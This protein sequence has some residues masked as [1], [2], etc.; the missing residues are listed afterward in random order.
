MEL[1]LTKKDRFIVNAAAKEDVRPV[2]HSIHV[3]KGKIEC[4]NGF[5]LV[6]RAIDYDGDDILLDI[7]DIAR[8]KDAKGLDG[9]IYTKDGDNI[10]AIGQ[11]IN[12]I[13]PVEGKFPDTKQLYPEGESVFEIGLGR[14]QMLNLLK[15]LDKDENTIRFTFYGKDKP[16]KFSIGDDV[17][18]LIM[19]CSL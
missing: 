16:V 1:K 2:L 13:S 11:D 17:K 4:A 9:V 14:G 15:C 7:S 5:I 3:T 12:I 19:P 10:K 8:H 6:E 18:G